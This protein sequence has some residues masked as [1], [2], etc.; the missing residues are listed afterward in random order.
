MHL[1]V[2]AVLLMLYTASNRE[3]KKTT[4]FAMIIVLEN[5]MP[6]FRN[7]GLV[8][9]RQIKNMVPGS[10]WETCILLIYFGKKI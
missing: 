9:C 1:Y 3:Q 7:R 8:P 10:C 6:M 2:T 5:V 4:L